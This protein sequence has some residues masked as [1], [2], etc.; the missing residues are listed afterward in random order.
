MSYSPRSIPQHLTEELIS[1]ALFYP[2]DASLFILQGS[3]HTSALPQLAVF[4]IVY[5]VYL[6]FVYFPH[7]R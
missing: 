5:F 2:C 6:Q 3:K 7:V 1:P 4:Y